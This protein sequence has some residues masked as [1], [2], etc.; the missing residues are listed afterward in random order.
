MTNRVISWASKKNE[1]GTFTAR[2][3]SFDYGVEEVT[4]YTYTRSSR[5]QAVG[6][7]KKAVKF[8]KAQQR[9]AA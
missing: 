1:D 3:Y 7:A 2:V 8:L 4:H 9:K 6:A 5:A